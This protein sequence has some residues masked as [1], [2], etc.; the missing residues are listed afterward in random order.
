L[1]AARFVRSGRF[2]GC[3]V[4][5]RKRGCGERQTD[6]NKV[7]GKEKKGKKKKVHHGRERIVVDSGC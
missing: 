7:G 5:K 3:R 2:Q 1:L 4:I 6:T